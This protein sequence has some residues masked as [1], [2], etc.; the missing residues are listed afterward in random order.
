MLSTEAYKQAMEFW[1]TFVEPFFGITPHEVENTHSMSAED[2]DSPMGD[3]ERDNE[4]DCGEEDPKNIASG[5]ISG[6]ST[7]PCAK[8]EDAEGVRTEVTT[9]EHKRKREVLKKDHIHKSLFF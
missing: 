8:A 2:E 5:N 1:G 6:P 4:A 7:P 3:D 9:I